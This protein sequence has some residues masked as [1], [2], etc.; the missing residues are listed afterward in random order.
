MS[1]IKVEFQT[2]EDRNWFIKEYHKKIKYYRLY[3]AS[4][5]YYMEWGQDTSKK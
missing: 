4:G 1:I 3:T 2:L 5:K